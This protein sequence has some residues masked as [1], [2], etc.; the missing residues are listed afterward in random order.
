MLDASF[1]ET[2]YQNNDIGW[3]LGEI[4]FPIKKYIDQLDNKTQDILIPGSGHA[5]EAEYL[6]HQG[7]ENVSIID[8]SETALRNFKKRVPTFPDSNLIQG[9]FFKHAS[10]YDLIIEQTFFCAIHPSLRQDYAKK[11]QE[12]LNPHG[13]VVGL[14]FRVPLNNDHPPFGGNKDAYI[15]CFDPFFR[16]AFMDP[17]YNSVA[18]RVDKELFF[19][20]HRKP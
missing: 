10:S 4:A 2:R 13:K 12:L 19:K 16:V 1:W 14:L 20:L 18:S 7:F 3:D 8:L 9:D 17:C 15:R 5:Y 11:M 6:H